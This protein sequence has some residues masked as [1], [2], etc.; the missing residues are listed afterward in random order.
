MP[1]RLTY[2]NSQNEERKKQINKE[3]KALKCKKKFRIHNRTEEIT[4]QRKRRKDHCR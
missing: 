4:R 2:S 3:R 1:L